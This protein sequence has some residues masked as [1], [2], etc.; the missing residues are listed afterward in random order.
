MALRSAKRWGLLVVVC[1]LACGE[2]E[3]DPSGATDE[4][5]SMGV[6]S[7]TAAD[8][9]T[10]DGMD[11]A[12]M[13]P[14]VGPP[15]PQ[16]TLSCSSWV[17][18][19]TELGVA[20]LPEIESTYG[21]DG[22]CWDGDGMQAATC[23]AECKASLD[24]AVMELETMGQ[25]VPETCDPPQT[26][27]W[28][29]IEAII[30]ANCVDACH[31]PGGEDASLDMSGNAYLE[32]YGVASSQSLLYLVEADSHEDSYLWHKVNGSQGS[33]GGSGS[34][35]PKGAPMLSAEDI[36]KI[37]TWIDAGAQPF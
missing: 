22:T 23:D 18:C 1:G 30:D 35:M 20:E 2:P 32:I 9:S 5:T 29:E 24:G 15:M 3:P 33:V 31:E 12:P 26:V 7:G 16:Q 17:M 25:P 11:T 13:L 4:G 27:S 28:G 37:A 21:I 10:G 34:T 19:A 8:T 14:D 6:A 36:E